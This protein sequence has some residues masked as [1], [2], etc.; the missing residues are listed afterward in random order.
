MKANGKGKAD[1]PYVSKWTEE[2]TLK[3]FGKA[4]ASLGFQTS[5]Q[6]HFLERSTGY[7]TWAWHGSP[8][9]C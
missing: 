9:P 3:G 1:W 2:R 6:S 7:C 5:L 4:Q 8:Y